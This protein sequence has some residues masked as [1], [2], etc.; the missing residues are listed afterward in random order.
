MLMLE[1]LKQSQKKEDLARRQ[2]KKVSP[3][4]AAAYG[5]QL[6]IY[7]E[8]LQLLCGWVALV[9]T[10]NSKKYYVTTW[11]DVVKKEVEMISLKNTQMHP[12]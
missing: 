9:T 5:R 8:N 1:N 3:R 6:K 7:I 11:F 2:E 12:K 4:A 10:H